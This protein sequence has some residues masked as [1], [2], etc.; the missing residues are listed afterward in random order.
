MSMPASGTRRAVGILLRFPVVLFLAFYWYVC[1]WWW[2][3]G[4]GIAAAGFVLI[5][6]PL[7]YLPLKFAHF[8]IL[9]FQNSGEPALPGYWNG[10]PRRYFD[11]CARC[12]R[13]G[14]PTLRRWL[15]EGWSG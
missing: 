9:A 13:L 3:A 10:Y 4:L 12:L 14:S 8:V 1:I 6:A 2:V 5:A 15:Y 11:W 7:L